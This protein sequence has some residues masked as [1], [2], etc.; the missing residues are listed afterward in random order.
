MSR[1]GLDPVI[2]GM[3]STH[4][5]AAN[6]GAG[7]L[8]LFGAELDL[9]EQATIAPPKGKGRPPGS[10]NRSTVQLQK[11]LLAKGYRD[12]AE[13]MAALQ[14]MDTKELAE[15]LSCGKLEAAQLQL[16]AAERLMPYFHQ[17]MPQAVELK[18]DTPR[19]LIVMGDVVQNIVTNQQVSLDG[20]APTVDLSHSEF[21]HEK[22]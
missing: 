1:S 3:Q 7:D 5:P 10:P 21:S 8:D 19:K 17:A 16:R 13:F 4:T 20:E 15:K 22:G 2:Q 14:S 6:D 18:T 9:F 12:P 11:L